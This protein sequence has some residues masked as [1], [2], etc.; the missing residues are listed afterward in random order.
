MEGE[1]YMKF[2]HRFAYSTKRKNTLY[3]EK[4][5]KY[6]T[7]HPLLQTSSSKKNDLKKKKAKDKESIPRK[8]LYYLL[9][10]IISNYH[11]NN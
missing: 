5:Y 4:I 1:E 3:L 2:T 9:V 10:V 8:Q 11:T 7:L 6:K